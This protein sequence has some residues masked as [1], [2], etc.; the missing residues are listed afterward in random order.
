MIAITWSITTQRD[1]GG[2][3]ADKLIKVLA[4]EDDARLQ[5]E[6]LE[7]LAQLR[8]DGALVFRSWM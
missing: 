1:D 8:A 6:L 4:G 7:A 2:I 3:P 5:V